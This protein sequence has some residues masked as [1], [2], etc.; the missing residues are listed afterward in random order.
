MKAVRIVAATLA[1]IAL[2]VV[3][4]VVVTAHYR[5]Q[6]AR[7]FAE[8]L[9][10]PYAISVEE[11]SVNSIGTDC[12]DLDAVLVLR[13][14]GGRILI[15]GLSM[16]VAASGLAGAEIA[17]RRVGIRVPERDPGSAAPVDVV[18]ILDRIIPLPGLLPGTRL[19]VA[20]LSVNDY[21]ELTELMWQSDGMQ[22]TLTARIGT[23]RLEAALTLADEGRSTGRLN[24]AAD[25]APDLAEAALTLHRAPG[26]YTVG[27]PFRLT[28]A[29]L[30]PV[31]VGTGL[32]PTA[33]TALD[34]SVG[35]EVSVLVAPEADRSIEV[36]ATLLIEETASLG[37][38]SAD[39]TPAA[40]RVLAA[41]ATQL[42]FAWPALDWQTTTPEVR[43][44]VDYGSIRDLALRLHDVV[45]RRGT[46]CALRADV[47]PTT[48]G[49]G[50]GIAGQAGDIE[51]A[52]GADGWQAD[53]RD[54]SLE[55]DGIAGPADLE[56]ALSIRPGAVTLD[57]AGTMRG[58]FSIAAADVRLLGYGIAVPA[59]A[60]TF[61]RDAGDLSLTLSLGEAGDAVAAGVVLGHDLRTGDTRLTLDDAR[62]D[63]SVRALS[64][65]VEG[66]P[67]DWD[68][69]AGTWTGSAD[70]RQLGDGSTEV[71]AVQSLD[72]IAGR[73]RDVAFAGLNTTLSVADGGWPLAEPQAIE[74]SLELID[75]G[76]PIRD[77]E[78][79]LSVDPVQRRV[80]VRSAG[81]DALGGRVTVDPF[82]FDPM[83]EA[84]S[85]TL[86]PES[87]QLPLIA[88]LANLTAL[89]VKGSVSG[90][91]P[92]AFGA[93]GVSIDGGRLSGDPPGGTIRYAASGC[94]DE[95][96]RARSGLEFA[97]CVMTHYEFDSLDSDVNYS[98]DGDLV[99]GMRLTGVN[100]EYDPQQPVNLNP[101]LTTNVVDLIRS[102]QAARSIEEVFDRQVQ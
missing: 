21:P 69:V 10:A 91:L 57:G 62:L 78:A 17:V 66:W 96:M 30:L 43:L 23:Y 70:L 19:S 95:V 50:I 63:F 52:I 99:I 68:V 37:Y 98:E 82:V 39:G 75:L 87:V 93:D 8:G 79:E 97:R 90:V 5:D 71:T 45:C 88:D 60:G 74:L 14:A 100:P 58:E 47:E 32:I 44:E 4:G 16:P 56:A 7:Q 49:P 27:G 54:V 80:A 77:V 46:R 94:T 59:A 42:A 86:R 25:D 48:L 9:L 72:A 24:I 15:E 35:G 92:I 61:A 55:V 38:L 2:V 1:A 12:I 31:L 51:V 34:A 6:I 65:F 41:A 101:T 67:N 3:I 28:A 64:E 29:P 22:Q 11:V 89:D 84:F 33:F 40:V 83:L 18:G 102:L 81:M 26:G 53:V 13:D 73:Y 36:V 76:F 85:V 20:G